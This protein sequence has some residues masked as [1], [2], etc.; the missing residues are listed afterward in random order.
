[1]VIK[2]VKMNKSQIKFFTD[3]A[4]IIRNRIVKR[5]E[6]LLPEVPELTISE[7]VSMIQNGSAKF[8]IE[9]FA[10]ENCPSFYGTQRTL[11]ELY[12]YP[13]E[14]LRNSVKLKT[15]DIINDIEDKATRHIESICQDFVLNRT[16]DPKEV[17]EDAEKIIFFNYKDINTVKKAYNALGYG[18]LLEDLLKLENN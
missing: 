11:E 14:D 3:Q 9:L 13:N 2:G 6:E 17:L 18:Y 5:H 15:A 4:N 1:M 10:N 8:K 12:E 16:E 7:M